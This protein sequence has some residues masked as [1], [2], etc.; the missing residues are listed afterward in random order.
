MHHLI[1][2]RRQ[3]SNQYAEYFTVPV[4]GSVAEWWAGNNIPKDDEDDT[5]PHLTT[6]IL[7]A[8]P[9]TEAEYNALKEVQATITL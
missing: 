2:G 7:S 6:I 4:A 8:I 3:G 9:I 5:K 1:T